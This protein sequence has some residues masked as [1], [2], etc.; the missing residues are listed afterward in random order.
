MNKDDAPTMSEGRTGAPPSSSIGTDWSP[1][2]SV[3]LV[4]DDSKA[5]L[6]EARLSLESG[7]DAC[8]VVSARDGLAA[9]KILVSQPVDL[10]LCDLVMEGLGGH[11]FLSLKATR[12]EFAD[13]P[14]IMLTGSESVDEKVRAL[15]GGAADYLIKPFDRAE[16]RARVRVHLRIRALQ[17]LLRVKNEK[18]KLLATTDELTGLA[19]RHRLMEIGEKE[20]S[21][22]RRYAHPL[23]CVMVDLDHFKR[24]NDTHG[25]LAGDAVLKAVG[26]ALQTALRDHDVAARY[27]GEEMLLLLPHTNLEGAITVAERHRKKLRELEVVFDGVKIPIS[28]SLGVSALSEGQGLTQ[29]IDAADGALYAAKKQGRDRVCVSTDAAA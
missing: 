29:L 22:A 19:N 4:V 26:A 10:I 1:A 16:L 11:R 7:E 12:K 15:G 17:Q 28:A 6:K 18:L 14:V 21:R 5:A 20:V 23:A 2:G 27:G 25:H 9:Y 13:I 8:H 3:I 24:V